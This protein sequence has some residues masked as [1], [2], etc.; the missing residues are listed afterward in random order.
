MSWQEGSIA[1]RQ[2][3]GVCHRVCVVGFHVPDKTWAIVVPVPFQHTR[4][5]LDCFASFADERLV[6]WDDGV[7]L[8]PRSLLTHLRETGRSL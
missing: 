4:M 6:A 7:T 5:C 8:Y 3:C 2:R 1:T